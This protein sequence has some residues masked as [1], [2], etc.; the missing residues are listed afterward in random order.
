VELVDLDTIHHQSGPSLALDSNG[1]P[2]ISYKD[3]F[4]SVYLASRIGEASNPWVVESVQGGVGAQRQT[5]LKIGQTDQSEKAFI[6]FSTDDGRI[7]LAS[8]SMS[9]TP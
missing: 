8:K 2:H 5:T 4:G 7:M 1:T 9:S 6:A 3:G